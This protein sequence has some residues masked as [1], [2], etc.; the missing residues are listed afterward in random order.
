V[1][2][3]RIASNLSYADL[4]LVPGVSEHAAQMA[5][6]RALEKLRVL[7]EDDAT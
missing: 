4:A 2:G 3:P 5:T 6:R 7:C 1:I